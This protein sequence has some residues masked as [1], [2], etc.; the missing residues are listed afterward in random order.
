MRRFA[1]VVAIP[2]RYKN[3]NITISSGDRL[4]GEAARRRETGSHIYIILFALGRLGNGIV[5]VLNNNMTG[6]TGGDAAAGVVDVDAVGQG[7]F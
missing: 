2:I 1:G 7:D 4:T 3:C 6:R 5:T